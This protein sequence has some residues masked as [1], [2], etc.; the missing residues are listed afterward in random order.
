MGGQ[1]GHKFKAKNMILG[2]SHEHVSELTPLLGALEWDLR[3]QEIIVLEAGTGWV[4][5]C[6]TD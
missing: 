3:S 5:S 1:E 2:M 6:H 4:L